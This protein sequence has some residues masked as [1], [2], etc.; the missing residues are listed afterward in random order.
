M[1]ARQSRTVSRRPASTAV[2]SSSSERGAMGAHRIQGKVSLANLKAVWHRLCLTA[3]RA[4][5]YRRVGLDPLEPADGRDQEKG[6]R[7]AMGA[8]RP[9]REAELGPDRGA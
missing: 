5:P 4:F 1:S 3:A 2:R 7:W 9:R 8:R 6:V